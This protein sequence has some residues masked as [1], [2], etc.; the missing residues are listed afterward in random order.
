MQPWQNPWQNP[1]HSLL[2]SRLLQHLFSCQSRHQEHHQQLADFVQRKARDKKHRCRALF[3]QPGKQRARYRQLLK[4]ARELE[5]R[6]D[7]PASV[8]AV[9]ASW[10][11]VTLQVTNWCLQI[12]QFAPKWCCFYCAHIPTALR[13]QRINLMC[14]IEPAVPKFWLVHGKLTD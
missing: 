10:R 3:W 14:C 9:V 8:H 1:W 4:A 7:L 12:V 5:L 6:P 13:H 11:V 2:V